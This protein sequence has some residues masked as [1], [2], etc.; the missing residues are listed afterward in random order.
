MPVTPTSRALDA[1]ACGGRPVG[2]SLSREAGAARHGSRRL[3]GLIVA[4]GGALRDGLTS[5]NRN[6]FLPREQQS[7]YD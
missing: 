7:D 6:R 3:A 5:E 1:A 4:R 2:V